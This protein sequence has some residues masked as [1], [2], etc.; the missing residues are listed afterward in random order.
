MKAFPYDPQYH[1]QHNG[2]DLR[3]WFAGKAM[4]GML[5]GVEEPSYRTVAFMA[6]KMADAMI[7]ERG[8]K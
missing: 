6:Y 8:E 4:E 5:V 2:M 1:T 7:E 3:D